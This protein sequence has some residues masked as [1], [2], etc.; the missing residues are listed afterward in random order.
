M[1]GSLYAYSILKLNEEV[2]CTNATV[3]VDEHGEI[4]WVDNGKIYPI[5]DAEGDNNE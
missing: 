4:S 2:V 3:I 1:P 5:F